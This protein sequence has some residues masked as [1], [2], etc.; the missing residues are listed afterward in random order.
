MLVAP[1][2]AEEPLPLSE[3]T[4]QASR[5]DTYLPARTEVGRAEL[6]ESHKSELSEVLELTPG[7]NVREGGRGEPRVDMRGFDQRA[8]LFTLNGV[9]VAEPYNG[10]INLNLFPLEMLEGVET[11]RGPSSSLYG[12]NGMAGTI[13]M[14]T[15]VPRAPFTGSVGTIWRE[16]NFWDVRASAGAVRNAVSGFIAGRFL[17][18]PGFPLSGSF[19]DRPASRRRFEDGGQRLNSDV[20]EKSLFTNLDYAYADEG[21]AHIAFL[22]SWAEFGIPPSTTAFA[23]V[24]RRNDHQ[25]LEHVQAGG[26]QR[27]TPTLGVSAAVFYSTYSTK[28]SQF[29]GPDFTTKL[30]STTADSDELGGIG[31]V[32]VDLADRDTLAVGGQVRG[33]RADISD[34]VSG[35][36]S[37]PDFITTSLAGENTYALTD[38]VLLI[39]GLSYDVQTGGGRSTDWQLNPQGGV[40]VDFGRFGMSRAAIARKIRFPTLRELFDPLQGNPNLNAET[41]LAYEIGH[42]VQL[43]NAYADVNFF[44]NDVDNLIEMEGGGEP[45]PAMN[46]DSAVLQ[47]VEVAVG[48]QPITRARLDVNYTY[49][50]AEASNNTSPSVADFSEIQHRPAHRFNGILRVFLP[51]QLLLR[52][53]GLYTS[54]QI[55]RF[56]SDV[57]VDGFGVF[58]VQLTKTFGAHLRVFAGLT[59][60]LDADYEEKLGSPQPGRRVF[61]GARAT[62]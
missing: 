15:V 16:S 31:R 57:T 5:L 8:V 13:K 33:A 10:I 49:L 60:A 7:I 36:L 39:T 50:D 34:T 25:E 46:L 40:W 41:T 35:H 44:R 43:A 2:S 62:Y 37:S 6:T 45:V 9:P 55:D 12:P 28:E 18:T 48:A 32:T 11:A 30:L 21:R 51:W 47:G 1:A 53:E 20:D 3:I 42:R 24:F 29:D 26:E 52:L 14:R 23:P 27:L 38:R 58:N 56:G 54:E 61:V 19:N 17:T 4:V 59:N 22:G